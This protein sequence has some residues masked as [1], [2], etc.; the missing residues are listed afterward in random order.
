MVLK[1]SLRVAPEWQQPGRRRALSDKRLQPM[2]PRRR[3]KTA[4]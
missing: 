1:L 4:K 2:K 3:V